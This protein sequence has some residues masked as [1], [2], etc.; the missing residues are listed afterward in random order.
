MTPQMGLKA[1]AWGIGLDVRGGV[2]GGRYMSLKSM[3]SWVVAGLLPVFLAGCSADDV[4]LNGKVFDALGVNTASVHKTPNLKAR[5]GIVLPPDL[6]SLPE[7]GSGKAQA[8]A[9]ADI[10]DHDEKRVVSQADLER[11]QAEFCQKHYED[12]RVH[13][14]QDRTLVE[15]PLGRCQKSIMSL[16]GTVNGKDAEEE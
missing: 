2:T 7:P 5:S 1:R 11:Q 6:S 14:D 8:P 10:Q 3:L 15:G 16:V 4:Q 13:G 12:A 9:L